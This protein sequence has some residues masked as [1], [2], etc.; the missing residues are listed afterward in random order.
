[1]KCVIKG[2]DIKRVKDVE[3]LTMVNSGWAY[4]KKSVWKEKVRGKKSQPLESAEAVEAVEAVDEVKAATDSN[5]SKYK[6]KSH[7]KKSAEARNQEI[8]E[9][10]HERFKNRTQRSTESKGGQTDS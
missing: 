10:S 8:S 7:N 1:M 4:C 5:G 6:K 3:A 9:K 2:E